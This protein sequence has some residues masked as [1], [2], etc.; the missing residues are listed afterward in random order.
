MTLDHA[1]EEEGDLG[2]RVVGTY[3]RVDLEDGLHG[4]KNASLDDRGMFGFEPLFFVPQFAKVGAVV[5]DL[6]DAGF[7][8]QFSRTVVAVL[9]RP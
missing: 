4:I 7:V 9:R 3:S 8:D 2:A 5:E 6:I 1:F